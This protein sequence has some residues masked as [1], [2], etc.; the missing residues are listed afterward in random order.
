LRTLVYTPA[1]PQTQHSS[2]IL[3]G[4]AI[5]GTLGTPFG[6]PFF[7]LTK[8]NPGRSQR[9]PLGALSRCVG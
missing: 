8:P 1:A 4:G 3:A 5:I 2:Q 9:F 6:T 7:G